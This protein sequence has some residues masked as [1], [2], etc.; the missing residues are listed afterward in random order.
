MNAVLKSKNVDSLRKSGDKFQKS[1]LE[2]I[3]KNIPDGRYKGLAK[4]LEP[5]EMPKLNRQ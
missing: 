1:L 2:R 5:H 3:E 4:I